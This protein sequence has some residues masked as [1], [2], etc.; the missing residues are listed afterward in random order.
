LFAFAGLWE[1]RNEPSGAETLHTCAIITAEPNKLVGQVHARMPVMLRPENEA[2]WLN[3]ESQTADIL[4]L[5]QPYPVEQMELAPVSRAV[6][7][8]TAAGPQLIERASD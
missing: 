5:L 1:E 3:P 7:S 8:A 4:S 2:A 6:N